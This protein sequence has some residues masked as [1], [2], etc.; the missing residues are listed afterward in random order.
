[1]QQKNSLRDEEEVKR[2]MNINFKMALEKKLSM[3]INLKMIHGYHYLKTALM[4]KEISR[5]LFILSLEGT[6]EVFIPKD[7]SMDHL[8][9]SF[10][11]YDHL[12]VTAQENI[13]FVK[14]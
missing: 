3:I 13:S 2:E 10:R 5:E 8:P 11:Y 7:L 12:I 4:K 14:R 6:M 1:M 9:Y